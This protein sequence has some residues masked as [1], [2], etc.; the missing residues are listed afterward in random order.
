MNMAENI[1]QIK[2]AGY[3]FKVL[4]GSMN[5]IEFSLGSH[6]YFMCANDATG[7]T[8]EEL[9]RSLEY[10]ERTLYLPTAGAG[11]NFVVNLADQVTDEEFVVTVSYPDRQETLTFAFNAICHVEGI[12]FALKREGEAWSQDVTKG[13]LPATTIIEAEKE[14]NQAAV[15]PSG[16]KSRWIIAII[17]TILVGTGGTIAWFKYG[18]APVPDSATTM[19]KQLGNNAGYSVQ[20]GRDKTYYLFAQNE[21]LADWA[22]RSISRMHSPESWKILTPQEERARLTRI[23]ERQNVAYF[24]IRLNDL[25]AP[26]LVLSSTRNATDP[27]TLKQI[28][29]V[30]LDATPYAE[31]INIELKSD[32]D[33]L[34]LAEEGLVALGFD[35]QMTQSDSGVT[36]SSTMSA[37]DSRMSELNRFVSQFYRLWGRHYVHF[38]MEL[39]DDALKEKSFKYGQ[40]GYVNMGKSHWLFK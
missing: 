31:K 4:S 6:S 24:T 40:D 15:K 20:Q 5:G 14:T 19:L 35:Y 36:L 18:A 38:S 27:V 39:R 2:P 23:L 8:N 21:Q 25:D 22:R 12:Y 26:T 3:V 7:G 16:W 9:A 29:K 17:L 34:R 10:A 13:V 30:L 1:D 28:K 32:Q 33:I 11:H 37:G